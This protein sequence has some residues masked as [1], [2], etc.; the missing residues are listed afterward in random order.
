MLAASARIG[1]E[2]KTVATDGLIRSCL[3]DRFRPVRPKPRDGSFV[4]G[5]AFPQGGRLKAGRAETLFH[6]RNPA[7]PINPILI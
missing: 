2:A 3:S 4:A 5:A 7:K 6:Y 1:P